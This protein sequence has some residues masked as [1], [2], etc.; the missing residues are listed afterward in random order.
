MCY[1]FKY[2]ICVLFWIRISIK[3]LNKRNHS[4]VLNICSTWIYA[5]GWHTGVTSIQ[6]ANIQFHIWIFNQIKMSRTKIWSINMFFVSIECN[7][8]SLI[9]NKS[10][11]IMAITNFCYG[12]WLLYNMIRN[13]FFHKLVNIPP[14]KRAEWKFMFWPPI[15]TISAST[16]WFICELE[17]FGIARYQFFSN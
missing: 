16:F 8:M 3:K 9:C 15:W 17:R 13:G 4:R 10:N 6:N 2:L 12:F 1:F 7:K 11:Q 5:F 14:K